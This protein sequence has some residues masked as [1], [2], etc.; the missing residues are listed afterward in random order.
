M[1][2]KIQG[3][4]LVKI[5]F[6]IILLM[7]GEY[8]VSLAQISLDNE[9]PIEVRFSTSE[10]A[11]NQS[12]VTVSLADI[13]SIISDEFRLTKNDWLPFGDNESEANH[14]I[15]EN[16][17]NVSPGRIQ[18]ENS[19]QQ[20]FFLSSF[21]NNSGYSFGNLMVAFD[22]VYNFHQRSDAYGLRLQYK[23]NDGEWNNARGGF[24][25]TSTLSSDEDEWRSFSI[26]LALDDI[27]LRESDTIHL[28]WVFDGDETIQNEIPL[29]LQR[30]E[31]VPGRID[32]NSLKRGDI[33]ITEVLPKSDVNGTDFEYVEVYNPGEHP[34]SIKGV[35]LIT[36]TG[37]RVIQ[38]DI[39]VEPYNVLVI[40]NVDISSLESVKNSYF[41]NG[42]IL[43]ETGGRIE[44]VR[45][46]SLIA[47]MTY[48]A[49]TEPGLALE[50]NRAVNAFDG[51]TSLQDLAPSQ[52]TY[53]QDLFG[54][55]GILGDTTPM[56]TKNLEERGWY[57]FSIPGNLVERLNRHTSVEFYSLEGDR[58]TVESITPNTPVLIHKLTNEP[59]TFWIEGMGNQ[60]S[61]TDD[62]FRFASNSAM[63]SA[64][65][66][67]EGGSVQSTNSGSYSTI[68]PVVQS[69]NER[70][71]K[72]ELDFADH[73]DADLWNPVVINRSI[74]ASLA[75]SDSPV[76]RSAAPI[77][78]RFIEFTLASEN[79]NAPI[80]DKAILGFM[81]SPSQND[82][83]RFDL[84][85]FA[86]LLAS[87]KDQFSSSS[88]YLS[89]GISSE[90]YNSF[91]H[92]P[93]DV[94]EEF[95]VALGATM[96]GSGG[97]ATIQWNLNNE[98]PDEWVVMFEDTFNG[99]SVDMRETNEYRFRF[100]DNT[101]DVEDSELNETPEVTELSP[102]D[103]PRFVIRV[104]PYESFAEQETEEETPDSIELR[105]NYPNPFNPSTNI[106]F[107][108]PEDRAVR[109]GIYNIVGQQVALLLDET[110]QAGEHSIVWD[111]S[112]KPSGIYIVQLE[113]GNRIFT[114]KITLIK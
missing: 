71:Q 98:I 12:L 103:L 114:R 24:L 23:V 46:G 48:E 95:E 5:L 21:Q 41:Y 44:L 38:Q 51:Y 97:T 54:S 99:T 82:D 42:S 39:I 9:N 33:I 49:P 61:V 79:G 55:P 85:K 43:S 8:A 2:K 19:S 56:V 29:A 67:N 40:S 87:Q 112:D 30:M 106:N 3:F 86:P 113:T 111:A 1:G 58:L 76:S 20:T 10:S 94:N 100:G 52:A 69:W 17:V 72:F 70:L 14:Y 84:P 35:E 77:L 110:M 25:D 88:I 47:S 66:L 28:M 109:V 36:P 74:S 26:Q 6:L 37:T 108:L 57:L 96:Y 27:Y 107:F 92:L 60:N 73:L 18:V 22:F 64:L 11:R 78:S 93:Y 34:V 68:A 104:E 32:Q 105:P 102:D 31:L 80:V 50:L 81:D 91:I 45:E 83:S 63:I 16:N 53:F 101:Q 4:Y 65:N 62:P 89:S 13:G 59:L 90:N 7:G 75:R 15:A